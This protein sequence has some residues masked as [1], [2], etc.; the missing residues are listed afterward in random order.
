LVDNA[1]SIVIQSSEGVN[2]DFVGGVVEQVLNAGDG[3]VSYQLCGSHHKLTLTD[4]INMAPIL[5]VFVME[6]VGILQEQC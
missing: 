2:G 4:D 1:G 3:A 5:N 6:P